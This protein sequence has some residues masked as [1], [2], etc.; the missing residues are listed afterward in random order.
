MKVVE[1]TEQQ[2]LMHKLKIE[3][4]DLMY[5]SS[6][7]PVEYSSYYNVFKSIIINMAES[8]P[9]LSYDVFFI[10]LIRRNSKQGSSK[11]HLILQFY[12]TI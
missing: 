11:D 1:L 9:D 12:H 3:Y 8:I 2:I 4:K 6:I 10:F 7:R 5:K